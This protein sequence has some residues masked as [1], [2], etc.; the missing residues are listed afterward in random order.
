MGEWT[1]EWVSDCVCESVHGGGSGLCQGRSWQH[2]AHNSSCSSHNSSCSSL[3][4][5]HPR[6][7]F[8]GPR[9]S[10]SSAS[11][12]RSMRASSWSA[13][14]HSTHLWLACGAS[15]IHARSSP[16]LALPRAQPG[17]Q[18]PCAQAPGLPQAIPHTCAWLVVQ[19]HVSLLPACRVVLMLCIKGDHV[20][21]REKWL[22]SSLIQKWVRSLPQLSVELWIFE[23]RINIKHFRA[24]FVKLCLL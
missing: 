2:V 22:I 8:S 1:S 4:K 17:G 20:L 23:N 6:S 11:G 19:A 15:S 21:K 3:I 18:D 13:T 7:L 9:P 10:A 5:L 24:T 16:G 14:S 12:S